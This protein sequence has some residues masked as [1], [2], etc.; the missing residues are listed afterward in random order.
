M[1]PTVGMRIS[2][3]EV[4]KQ[5]KDRHQGVVHIKGHH[6]P[7]ATLAEV[8]LILLDLKEVL[9]NTALEAV[10]S[11]FNLNPDVPDAKL[12][13]SEQLANNLLPLFL[14]QNRLT[15]ETD[16]SKLEQAHPR[17]FFLHLA[18]K[19]ASSQQLSIEFDM[20]HGWG[21]IIGE[22]GL[23][24]AIGDLWQE[25]L[26]NVTITSSCKDITD[27]LQG[28]YSDRK[29]FR[30]VTPIDQ[31]ESIIVNC[32]GSHIATPTLSCLAFNSALAIRGNANRISLLMPDSKIRG[33]ASFRA[34]YSRLI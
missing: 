5:N 17:L 34:E 2:R 24:S 31:E 6:Y 12:V 8:S 20:T 30:K 22:F 1:E 10:D 33:L 9:S 23:F 14:S 11:F 18:G 19:L 29:V 7:E 26:E 32:A 25:V 21:A 3:I 4:S 15:K 16:L 13:W 28:I 27:I